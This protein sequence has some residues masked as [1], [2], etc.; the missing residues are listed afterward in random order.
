MMNAQENLYIVF[1]GSVTGDLWH[2]AAAQI[3]SSLYPVAG[4]P[5]QLVALIAITELDD[6]KKSNKDE[7]AR[8]S[9]WKN[10]EVVFNYLRSISLDCLLVKCLGSP[11]KTNLET[12][13]ATQDPGLFDKALKT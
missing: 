10:A 11:G 13:I 3:L 2:V 8:N 5:Y 1:P 6:N 4:F 9:E 7:E 12:N